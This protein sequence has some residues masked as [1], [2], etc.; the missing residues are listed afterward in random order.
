MIIYFIGKLCR[1]RLANLMNKNNVI[2]KYYSKHCILLT[3]LQNTK[4]RQ[5]RFGWEH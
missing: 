4:D 1:H 2:I 5:L 3:W